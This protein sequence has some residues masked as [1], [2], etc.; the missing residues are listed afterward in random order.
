MKCLRN[1]GFLHTD[2]EGMELPTALSWGYITSTIIQ[3]DQ[4]RR[5]ELKLAL[6]LLNLFSDDFD[7][8]LIEYM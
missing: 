4:H 5:V 8:M 6:N 1:G 2:G 3:C 7:Q